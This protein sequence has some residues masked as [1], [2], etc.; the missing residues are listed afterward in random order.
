MSDHTEKQYSPLDHSVVQFMTNELVQEFEATDFHEALLF[1]IAREIGRVHWNVYQKS[2]DRWDDDP[3]IP[4]IH[5]RRYRYECACEEHY[6]D[7]FVPQHLPGCIQLTPCFEFAGVRFN[8]Y[9]N[10]GRGMSMNAMKTDTEWR[11]WF[12]ACITQ[13]KAFGKKL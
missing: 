3:K 4:E 13:I 10:P 5:W 6:N 11:L 8:W 12:E 9:K 2:W 7:P 1:G